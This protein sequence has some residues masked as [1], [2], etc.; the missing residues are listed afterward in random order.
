MLWIDNVVTARLIL[1]S[2]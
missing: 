1:S 2:V